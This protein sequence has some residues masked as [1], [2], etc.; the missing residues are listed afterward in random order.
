MK[1][2]LNLRQSISQD[3]VVQLNNELL[4]TRLNYEFNFEQNIM[5]VYGDA[6]DVRVA[7]FYLNKCGFEVL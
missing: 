2:I 4:N 5:I 3:N 1:K 6:N 7:S